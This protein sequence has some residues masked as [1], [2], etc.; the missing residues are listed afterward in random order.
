[1]AVLRMINS[2]SHVL[3]VLLNPLEEKKKHT[4]IVVRASPQGREKVTY[5]R[6]PV[7]ETHKCCIVAG[8]ESGF[9]CVDSACLLHLQPAPPPSPVVT[10]AIT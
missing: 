9:R 4:H 3:S 5:F 1:M 7:N 10:G 8:R 2:L 6:T